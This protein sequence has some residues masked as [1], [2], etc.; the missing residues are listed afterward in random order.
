MDMDLIASISIFDIFTYADIL[1]FVVGAWFV[2]GKFKIARGWSIV[3]F[4]NM[5]KLAQCADREDEGRV[6]CIVTFG[7]KVI[8]VVFS[9]LDGALLNYPQAELTVSLIT[10]ILFIMSLV[11]SI[12]VY[13]GLCEILNKRKSWVWMLTFLQ[14]I[15]MFGWGISKKIQPK[16]LR[17]LFDEED[18]S[19]ASLSGFVAEETD[20]GL[21]VNITQRTA[22]NH[23][24]TKVLL[25]D[26]HMNIEPG[27]MVLL[28]GGSGAGKTT[29]V[30]A[31]TGYEKAEAKI[32]LDGDNVYERFDK[33]KYNIGFV[34]QQ[35]L[36]RYNDTVY[37]TLSDAATLRLPS[38]LPRKERKARIDKVLDI[39]GLKPIK[40]NI[41]GKQSGGQKKRISIATEFISDPSL[42]I[43]DEPDSG[44]DG[45]LARDLMTRLHDISREGKIVIVITHTPDRVIDLFDKVIVLGKDANR[46]GRLVYYGAIDDARKF[47]GKDK[48][49]DIVR[50]INKE[51]EGG[52]G[53]SDELIEKFG[54]VRDA[55]N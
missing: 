34:P 17:H 46:T 25:K 35:D 28:L 21:S 12:R 14:G 32:L 36:I 47:F 31:I 19:A 10:L 3:P 18:E 37:K 38:S 22:K 9:M 50:M 54:E 49:E 42:F 40:N 48:M 16:T 5:Y 53:K 8:N 39:F 15:T 4:A 26:I 11:Y 23:L 51:D 55:R 20:K 7:Y 1:L 44:L 45:I 41:V 52:E 29:F 24:K 2:F 30:N 6:F 43:L 27:N 33:M 13:S